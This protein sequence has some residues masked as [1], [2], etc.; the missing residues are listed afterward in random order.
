MWYGSIYSGNT[1]CQA[2]LEVYDAHSAAITVEN[3][4]GFSERGTV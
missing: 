4:L 1:V 3:I 2:G